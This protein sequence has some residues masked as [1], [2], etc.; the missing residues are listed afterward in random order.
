MKRNEFLTDLQ[1]AVPKISKSSVKRLL[2]LLAICVL[3]AVIFS[4]AMVYL[5]SLLGGFEKY[6]Y[7]GVF[8]ANL[9]S[10][11]TVIFPA[12]P[13]MAVTIAVAATANPLW[14]AVA[15][16]IGGALGEITAYYVGFGGRKLTALDQDPR[17]K[18]AE[19]WMKRYGGFAIFIFAFIPIFIF[20]LVG[21]VAGVLRFPIGKFLLFCW[22]GRLPRAFIEA[23]LGAWIFSPFIDSLSNWFPFLFH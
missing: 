11:F 14:A 16:S 20:D 12:P 1:E 2:I 23:Y 9:L 4:V 7:L 3:L 8:I 5:L 21:I 10:S 22:A 15:A 19:K 18:I 13:G 17:Y 6:G